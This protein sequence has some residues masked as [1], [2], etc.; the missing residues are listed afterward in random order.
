MEWLGVTVESFENPCIR[1]RL[2]SIV[3]VNCQFK[4]T[5]KLL[6]KNVFFCVWTVRQHS[7]TTG[8]LTKAWP[9]QACLDTWV[10]EEAVT[11]SWDNMSANQK[12]SLWDGLFF[13]FLFTS[14]Q[15]KNLECLYKSIAVRMTDFVLK[16]WTL[17]DNYSHQ[18]E[19]T[20]DSKRLVTSG[21]FSFSLY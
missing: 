7:F 21:C 10:G 6:L 18:L 12:W 2:K 20:A 15:V 8:G 19:W 13:P 4:E 17:K 3:T 16:S 5:G 9:W 1:R 14:V 11:W